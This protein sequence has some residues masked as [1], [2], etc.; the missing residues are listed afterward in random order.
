MVSYTGRYQTPTPEMSIEQVRS[1]S[2]QARREIRY[3]ESQ[4]HSREKCFPGEF[5]IYL[6]TCWALGT[7]ECFKI[8]V[9]IQ[10]T[11][12]NLILN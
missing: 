7:M 10:R 4:G 9:P 12:N 3:R 11:N 6:F 2:T 1:W 5:N 8:K